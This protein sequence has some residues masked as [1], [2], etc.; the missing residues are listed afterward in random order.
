MKRQKINSSTYIIKNNSE[1][2]SASKTRN[3]ALNDHCLDYLK[4]YN[5]KK[6]TDKPTRKRK[7][8]SQNNIDNFITHIMKKGIKFEENVMEQ[9]QKK[10]SDDIVKIGHSYES[11]SNEKYNDTFNEMIKGTPIIYQPVLYNKKKKTFGCVDLIIRS[12][13]INKIFNK[14]SIS[15][16]NKN[17]IAHELK[18]YNS[19]INYHY[20]VVDIKN[21]KIQLNSDNLT[22][23]NKNNI[24]PYKF[25]LT[26]YNE[27]LGET[28]GH[29]PPVAYILGNGWYNDKEHSN[30]P[31]DKLLVIDYNN[32]DKMYIKKTDDAINWYR[33]LLKSNN[34][35]H[36]PP[37][38]KELYPNMCNVNDYG[39]RNIK[40]QIAEKYC[41]ITNI[42]NCSVKNRNKCIDN[43]II[44]WK[45]PR[46][47]SKML[48]IKNKKKCEIID[49][50]LDLNRQ[51]KK[52]IEPDFITTNP[53]NWRDFKQ[54][55]FYVDFEI[56]NKCLNGND[57][58]FL[59]GIGNELKG[60]WNYKY[61]MAKEI[62]MSEEKRIIT[63]F[64]DYIKNFGANNNFYHWNHTERVAYYKRLKKYKIPFNK[65]NWVDV[66][67]IFRNEPI[68]IKGVLNFSL[69]TIAKKMYEYKMIK[70]TWKDDTNGLDI[71]YNAWKIYSKKSDSDI[72]KLSKIIKYN[73]I[74]CKTVYEII[75]FLQNKYK[76]ED[77]TS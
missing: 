57:F 19:T 75:K 20:R 30:D 63:E 17:D 7:R 70:T 4:L 53:F 59:I 32:K 25:Q 62:N 21:S 39:Y 1:W 55:G 37:C 50:I 76:L 54:K 15:D 56:I 34:W 49:K 43:N 68:L 23:R 10:F 24:K 65:I 18:K 64:N 22:I 35:T 38:R 52:L 48:G 6:I 73:E 28:Q 69:K 12:D 29:L 74:D 60:E 2:I 51:N 26:V 72:T 61:F 45:D 5:I 33:E 66:L 41:E 9:L 46:C 42:W 14:K 40:K 36:N 58:I 16:D 67:N 71:M 11:V 77:N 3:A 13:W 47:T 27:A 44:S 31:F 8:K